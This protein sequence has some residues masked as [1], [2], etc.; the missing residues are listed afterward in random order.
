VNV[1][2]PVGVKLSVEK[3][4]KTQEE[5]ENMSSVQ[6]ASAIGILMYAMV[7]VRRDITHAVGVLIRV[8]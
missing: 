7:C 5:E 6:Y 2:I 8:M 3:C 4:P 1:P